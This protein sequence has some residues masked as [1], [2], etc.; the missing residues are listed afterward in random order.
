[1]SLK[2]NNDQVEIL[3][4]L[5]T[6]SADKGNL[7]NSGMVLDQEGNTIAEAE[8]LVVS[9]HNATDH[10]ERMLVEKVCKEKG[11]HYTAG[12]TMITVCQ[13]CLMCLSA[14][15]QAGYKKIAYIIPAKKY[16]EQIPW[17]S[18]NVSI[19]MEQLAKTMTD[20]IEMIHLSEYENE[21]SEVFEKVMQRHLT[22]N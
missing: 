14:C 7:A 9:N 3:K 15:S 12:L 2:L 4:K 13:P 1:M 20:P 16:V 10:S 5:M 6:N 8:S 21:F 19:D 11:S 18:D 22:K 17:M